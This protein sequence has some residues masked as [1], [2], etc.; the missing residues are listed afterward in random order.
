MSIRVPSFDA[1]RVTRPA[2]TS[3][4][5]GT[6]A[7]DSCESAIEPPR[8]VS[9]RKPQYTS[10]AMR[11]RIQGLVMMDAVVDATGAVSNVQVTRS[12]DPQLDEQAVQAL[13][14]WT[15]A[16][17]TREGRPVAVIVSVEMTF[18]LRSRR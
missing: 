15:F 13:R 12:L 14:Q 7:I 18:S 16:P 1:V 4:V 10:E 9:D 6:G 11:A 2:E 8:L 17:A 5:F 3:T